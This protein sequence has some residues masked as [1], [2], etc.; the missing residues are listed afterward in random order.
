MVKINRITLQNLEGVIVSKPELKF[1]VG[2][3]DPIEGGEG[4]CCY[5]VHYTD[6]TTHPCKDMDDCN[7][8]AGDDGWW[9]CSDIG[10]CAC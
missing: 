3:S 6:Y 7:D 10:S 8:K 9:C 2:G 5:S 1:I 4:K